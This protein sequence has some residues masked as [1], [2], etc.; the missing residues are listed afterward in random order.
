[1][2]KTYRKEGLESLLKLLRSPAFADT[3]FKN[4]FQDFDQS[5]VDLF[6]NFIE[7]VNSLLQPEHKLSVKKGS[8]LCTELRILALIRLGIT[9]SPKI[10][11]AL[12]ISVR[13]AYCYRNRLRYKAICPPEEFENHICEICGYDWNPK[14]IWC[15]D[16]NGHW[17]IYDSTNGPVPDVVWAEG[18]HTYEKDGVKCDKCPYCRHIDND[19]NNSCDVC[20]DDFPG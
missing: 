16:K 12:N 19:E 4:Y 13:T 17:M 10:A 11:R 6:P 7:E 1:M 15:Y 5:I 9:D 3:E 20:G 18:E 8:V 14:A 2:R